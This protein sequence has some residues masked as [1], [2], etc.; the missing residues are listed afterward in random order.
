MEPALPDSPREPFWS[1]CTWFQ[2]S[3]C[4]LLLCFSL[5]KWIQVY[6]LH[7]L[8]RELFCILVYSLEYRTALNIQQYKHI[9]IFTTKKCC[10]N[11]YYHCIVI[12]WSGTCSF[13]VWSDKM[14]VVSL[15]TIHQ[16]WARWAPDSGLASLIFRTIALLGRLGSVLSH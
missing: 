7:R 6:F 15:N 16:S 1:G 9:Q 12:G 3:V 2:L 4:L 13:P 8:T 11:S 10:A 5:L 14:I